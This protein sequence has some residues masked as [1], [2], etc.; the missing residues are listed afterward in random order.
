MKIIKTAEDLLN[1]DFWCYAT[2]ENYD[3]LQELGITKF[4]YESFEEYIDSPIKQYNDVFNLLSDESLEEV[5]WYDYEHRRGEKF[6]FDFNT[7]I[8]KSSNL[9]DY[10]FQEPDSFTVEILKVFKSDE[11]TEYIGVINDN[12]PAKWN[13]EGECLYPSSVYNLY[14]EYKQRIY[15]KQNTPGFFPKQK[16]KISWTEKMS[17]GLEQSGWKL[18]TNEEIDL[19]KI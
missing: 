14:R 3:A 11:S 13:S 17:L 19:F 15:T 1:G 7:D 8:Q 18:A 5:H 10:G 9:E 6:G 12:I 2:R 16:F 4:C